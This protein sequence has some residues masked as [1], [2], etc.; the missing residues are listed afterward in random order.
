[1]IEV[2]W[3]GKERGEG[4]ENLNELEF[5]QMMNSHFSIPTKKKMSK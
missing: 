1:M 3:G 5:I 2:S 4:F